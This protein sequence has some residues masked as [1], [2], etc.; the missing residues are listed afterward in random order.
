MSAVTGGEHSHHLDS[1]RPETSLGAALL[2]GAPAEIQRACAGGMCLPCEFKEHDMARPAQAAARTHGHR[3]KECPAT[4]DEAENRPNKG[5]VLEELDNENATVLRECED[6][7][8]VPVGERVR[9]SELRQEVGASTPALAVKREE[10]LECGLHG[11]RLRRSLERQLAAEAR[12]STEVVSH[13]LLRVF[14]ARRGRG[15]T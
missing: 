10:P 13:P 3:M 15:R 9:T 12:S 11:T 6:C 7:A 2:A 4:V 1:L 8:A 14:T 5:S